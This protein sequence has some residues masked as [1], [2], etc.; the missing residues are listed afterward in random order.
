MKSSRAIPLKSISILPH[1]P[2]LGLT[3]G[4]FLSDF[5]TEI[6]YAFIISP[7]HDTS[8]DHLIFLGSITL[9]MFG[10]D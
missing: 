9:L 4:L 1:H 6:L 2:C 5:R 7:N 10:K 3:S 8:R